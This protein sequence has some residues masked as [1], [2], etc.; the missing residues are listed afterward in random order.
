MKIPDIT[1]PSENEILE[2]IRELSGAYT[3]EWRFDRENPDGG[4]ALARIYAEMYVDTLKKF[5]RLPVKNQLEFFR[6]V[7]T[8]L[9]AA[10]PAGGYV[11]FG[12]VNREVEGTEVRRGTRLLADTG[13]SDPVVFETVNDVYVTPTVI[14]NIVQIL[15]ESDGIYPVYEREGEEEPGAFCLFSG[16]GENCQEHLLYLCHDTVFYL[17]GEGRIF[18]HLHPVG[19][20]RIEPELLEGFADASCVQ[21]EYSGPEGFVPFEGVEVKG[22]EICLHKGSGQPPA[23]KLEWRGKTSFWIR[24]RCLDIRRMERLVVREISV[25]ADG[26]RLQ[27]DMV[28]A[29]GQEQKGAEYLPFGEQMGLYTEAYFASGQ[30]LSRKG[31]KITLSFRMDFMKIPT[32]NFGQEHQVDWKLVMKQSD[33]IPDPEYDIAIREVVWEYFNGN[34]WRKLPESD[35]YSKI[36]CPDA[37][38]LGQQIKLTFLCPE[39]M[40]PVLVQ[41]VESFYVRARVLKMDNM[42]RWNGQY[43]PPVL[44]GTWFRVE[45]EEPYPVPEV[46]LAVNNLEEQLL[47][48]AV[49]RAR[50]QTFGPFRGLSDQTPAVYMGFDGAPD[51]GPVRLLFCLDGELDRGCLVAYEFF[52]GNRWSPL[53]V[54][55]GTG[56]FQK[57]GILTFLGNS[58]FRRQRLWGRECYW[59]R[60]RTVSVG[61]RPEIKGQMGPR[62]QALYMNV[63]EALA[64]ETREPELF[65]IE[66]NEKNAQFTLLYGN[67]YK[68]DVWVMEAGGLTDAQI[69]LLRKRYRVEIRNTESGTEREVWV[70][71]QEVSG[72]AASGADDR[73]YQI[74]KNEGIIRFSDGIRGKIPDSGRTDTICVKYQSGGGS[75]G[76]V[77]AG[78]VNRLGS[79]V[80]FIN[81]V[82]NPAAMAGG[83]DREDVEKAVFRKS[84]ELRHRDRAVTSSD[85]EALALESAGCVVRARCYTN[86]T[87]KGERVGGHI[88]LVLLMEEHYRNRAYFQTVKNQCLAYFKERVPA[89][90]IEN[91]CF[92]VREPIFVEI[93]VKAVVLVQD[94]N[95]V[96][97]TRRNVLSELE[98]F[99]DP[100]KGNFEGKGWR[101]GEAPNQIQIRNLLRNAPGVMRVEAMRM[102]AQVQKQDRRLEISIEDIEN[103]RFAVTAGGMH[104]IDIL[105]GGG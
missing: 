101:I 63:T 40:E 66:P 4:T 85:Y 33:F 31:A 43:I 98:R 19:N 90:M 1:G 54:I 84:R 20:S 94:M 69:D 93:S 24:I 30:V 18:L 21:F 8:S 34:D 97:E 56:G 2:Q 102:T 65:Y 87:E 7:G 46:L 14:Q 60:I 99:F 68:A 104:E 57:T 13:E 23:A 61:G 6:C 28:L 16:E 38:T 26:G 96:L 59:I 62:I 51:R 58:G 55:D 39:D 49:L 11:S 37:G 79:T 12:L 35:K 95:D 76:N 27:P 73:H 32:E 103:L 88:T 72:F 80:G 67:I 77:P 70:R 48:G 5:K 100:I 47:T 42:Y 29:G 64:V 50:R 81:R 41:S 89:G 17:K 9:A 15:P 78:A 25:S 53:N 36:F 82:T 92:H 71:W 75:K 52:D 74:D 45:Y 105:T 83:T 22:H 10:Q 3:P 86:C 44:S 91:G